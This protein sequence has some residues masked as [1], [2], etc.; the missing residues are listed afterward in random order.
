VLIID[1]CA[2]GLSISA[3][4]TTASGA[5]AGPC[6]LV[7]GPNSVVPT[8]EHRVFLTKQ[9]NQQTIEFDLWEG[10]S[11]D[12]GANTHLGRFAVVELPPA[13]AGEVLALVEVTIDVDGT[14]RLAGAELLSSQ[15]LSIEQLSHTGLPRIEIERLASEH[16]RRGRARTV[17]GG[18]EGLAPPVAGATRASP[19]REPR[20]TT[21]PPRG[22]RGGDRW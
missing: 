19:G 3:A 1:V 11:S 16:G 5:P 21:P 15:G 20:G 14:V 18:G 17:S 12:A 10:S 8:R 7:I 22:D 2:R 13:P 9:D 4:S 6:D